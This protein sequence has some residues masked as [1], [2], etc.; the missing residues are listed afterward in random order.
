[1]IFWVGGV[2]RRANRRKGTEGNRTAVAQWIPP[3]GDC[4]CPVDSVFLHFF[5]KGFRFLSSQTKNRMRFF[6][7]WASEVRSYTEMVVMFWKG[8]QT[9][10][11]FGNLKGHQKKSLHPPNAKGK[12]CVGVSM[13]PPTPKTPP[14]S[15][16]HLRPTLRHR[17]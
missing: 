3:K 6:P 5:W 14:V 10:S 11:I 13:P 1:M 2:L 15:A 7:I 16:L 17:L 8:K 9:P 12:P 4:S